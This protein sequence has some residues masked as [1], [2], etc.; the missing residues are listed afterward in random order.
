LSG[1]G[2]LTPQ[3]AAGRFQKWSDWID[4]AIVAESARWGDYRRDAHQ[5]KHGPYELHTRDD[6]WQP[7]I[8]RLLKDCFPK[9]TTA[10][11]KQLHE[12]GLCQE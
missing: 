1:D 11:L 6:H 12:A 9:R 10:F 3:P 5:Y 7:E 4:K 2:V 8:Q